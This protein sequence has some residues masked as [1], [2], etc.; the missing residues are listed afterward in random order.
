MSTWNAI[1]AGIYSTLKSGTAL[2]SLL[3]GTAAIYNTLAPSTATEPYVVF[4]LQAGGPA[5]MNPSDLRDALV[6]VRAYSSTSMAAAG[7][8]DTQISNLLHGKTLT[9]SGYTNWWTAR[10]EEFAIAEIRPD[11]TYGYMAGAFYR[12][13]LDA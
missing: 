13:R 4:S 6:Y 12:V 11:G 1:S 2:T 3:S 9:V 10:E 5:N 7:S 8:I